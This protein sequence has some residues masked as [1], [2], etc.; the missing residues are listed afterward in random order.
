[1]ETSN[2]I[3]AT[4][5]WPGGGCYTSKQDACLR[6]LVS[7]GAGTRAILYA[8][9]TGS[10]LLTS[11]SLTLSRF[12]QLIPGAT[13]R[14]V[15]EENRTDRLEGDDEEKILF[16]AKHDEGIANIDRSQHSAV[17]ETEAFLDRV[18]DLENKGQARH[19]IDVIFQHM[20]S[21]LMKRRFSDCDDILS[22]T[23]L[24][25]ISPMLM[26]AFLTITAAARKDLTNRPVFFANV[27]LLV[28]AD[29]GTEAANRLLVGLR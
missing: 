1:M 21:L 11:H 14:Y 15:K 3:T 23:E 24:R 29:R 10:V 26:A 6:I 18:Y 9:P 13:F 20:N 12:P 16:L 2:F 27:R 8:S 7:D 22:K 28:E 4:E 5:E 25:S 17:Q 19:A